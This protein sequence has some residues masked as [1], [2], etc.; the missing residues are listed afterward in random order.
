VFVHRGQHLP[1]N[2]NQHLL[3]T[4]GRDSHHM[5][6]GLVHATNAVGRKSRRHRLDTLAL[7]GQ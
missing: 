2:L 4:P 3:V 6:Q 5:M 1:T 7:S